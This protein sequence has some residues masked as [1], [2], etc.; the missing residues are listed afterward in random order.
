MDFK[1]AHMADLHLGG[2]RDS[3]LNRISLET[4]ED[5]MD[6]CITEKVDFILISG[7]LF[8]TSMPSFDV[9]D[10]V[11]KKLNQVRQAGIPVYTIS[12]SHDF[13]PSGKTILKV[14]ENAEL[15]K[16]VARG[17]EKDGKLRLTFT[18]DKKTGAKLTGI[19]GRKGQLDD[20][21]YEHLDRS[22]EKEPGFKIFL[23]H[24]GIEE[25]KP[26]YLK[27]VRAMPLSLMPKN[28]DYYAGGHIHHGGEYDFH[29][30]KMVFPGPLFPCNFQEF[31]KLGSGGFY[32]VKV[33]AGKISAEFREIKKYDS[34]IVRIDADK[35]S[36]KN[37]ESET[38]KTLGSLKLE[39]TILLLKV[40]GVLSEGKPSDIDFRT[41]A[42]EAVSKGAKV[43]KKSIS[44]LSSKEF[45]E[46]KIRP[47]SIEN[48]EREVIKEHLGQYKTGLA[49][50]AEPE[51]IHA[52]MTGMDLE[53][54]EGETVPVFEARVLEKGYQLVK[55]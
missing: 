36:A 35:K 27:D 20:V 13:S 14:L 9:L 52:I 31:E 55:K 29:Q 21:Y 6:A 32:I 2:W 50:T 45:K 5:S 19:F 37:V 7:D 38:M 4:F 39:N 18:T 49:K 33:K 12:G 3:E 30:R 51:L 25:F 44:G 53:K 47:D 54:M 34:K 28:F 43:V 46:I 41:I 8:D 40:S 15:I 10:I 42:N 16:D 11:S 26:G 23:F 22:I 24:S 17:E 48:L 1:F